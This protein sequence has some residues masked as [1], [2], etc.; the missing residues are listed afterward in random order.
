LG[1][2]GH[3]IGSQASVPLAKSSIF[4]TPPRAKHG[5]L[6]GGILETAIHEKKFSREE[7]FPE[8]SH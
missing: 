2:H 8:E 1:S 5:K 4:S 7:I 6:V 3:Y